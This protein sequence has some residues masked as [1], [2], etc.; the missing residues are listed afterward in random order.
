MR[1]VLPA[2]YQLID[3]MLLLTAFSAIFWISRSRVVVMVSH[4]LY[5]ISGSNLPIYLLFGL[6][7][8]SLTQNTK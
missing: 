2:P 6:S 5:K 4:P 8:S 7:R 3:L 1:D